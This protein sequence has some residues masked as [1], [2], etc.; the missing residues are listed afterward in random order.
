MPSPFPGMNPYLEQEECWQDFHQSFIPLVRALLAEQV[1]PAYVVKVEEHLFIHE[2][3]AEERRLLGRADVSLA[4][5]QA[6]AAPHAA[7]AILDAPSYARL[8]VAVDVEQHSY[9]EIRDRRNRELITVIELLS[10]SNKRL[11]PDREQYLG[12]RLQFLHSSVHLVEIDLLRG[13]PRLPVD[14]LEEC[15][16]YALVSRW[17][18]RPRTAVW[19]IHLRDRLPVLPIP[20]RAP[21]PNAQLDLQAVLHRLYDE[22]GYADYIYAGAPQPPLS[23]E[24]DAWARSFVPAR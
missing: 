21:D 4:A 11:G 19:P 13:G 10:P 12:K 5:R 15:D 14:E 6:S 2:L 7:A 24:D 17:Q 18:D 20:L 16:Y 9:L 23:T 1:R 22:A 3:S 8:P